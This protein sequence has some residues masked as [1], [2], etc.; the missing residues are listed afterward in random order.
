MRA[1]R[2]A[3]ARCR[4]CVTSLSRRLKVRGTRC[5]REYHV[6]RPFWRR[7]CNAWRQAP[8]ATRVRQARRAL[9][10]PGRL[11]TR[12]PAGTVKW[13]SSNA[14]VR[15]ARSLGPLATPPLLTRLTGPRGQPCAQRRP[16]KAPAA[17]PAGAPVSRTVFVRP[18]RHTATCNSTLRMRTCTCPSMAARA[19]EHTSMRCA[20]AL[21]Q[22]HV[23]SCRF[24]KLRV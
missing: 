8:C 5:G 6:L 9:R 16:P 2:P 7:S 13:S 11:T 17:L 21:F 22:G 18:A 20:A 4:G 19:R 24:R 23:T 1:R 15:A 14:T 10:T 12:F 3:P